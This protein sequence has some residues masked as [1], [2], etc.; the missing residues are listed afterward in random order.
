MQIRASLWLAIF[1]LLSLLSLLLN[2]YFECHVPK[3]MDEI[4]RKILPEKKRR[5]FQNVCALFCECVLCVHC[6]QPVRVNIM[7]FV[8][9]T[10][11]L[12]YQLIYLHLL[13]FTQNT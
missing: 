2:S 1:I 7:A 5:P 8:V 11:E 13:P 12:L 4:K 6:T 10:V 3:W 9:H